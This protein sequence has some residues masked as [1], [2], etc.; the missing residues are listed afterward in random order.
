MF[1]QIFLLV[2]GLTAASTLVYAADNGKTNKTTSSQMLQLHKTTAELHGDS[3]VDCFYQE[4]G[5]MDLCKD[6]DQKPLALAAPA[7]LPLN[8]ANNSKH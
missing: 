2:I 7:S 1:K 6:A 4:N 8:A 5:E 3:Y